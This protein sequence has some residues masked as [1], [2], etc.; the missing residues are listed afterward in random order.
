MNFE[1]MS[2]QRK[3]VLI[4]AAIGIISM[5]LPWVSFFGRNINGMRGWGIVVFFCFVV[6]A[7]MCLM[8]DQ[9]KNLSRT[10]WMV[11]MI[12]GSIAVLILGI[13]F[14]RSFNALNLV[15]FGFYGAWAAAVGVTSWAYN[16]R[17][18]TDSLQGGFDS[19]KENINTKMKAT[20]TNSDNT[21]SGNRP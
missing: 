21:A 13:S 8:G 5:F 14:I 4:A 6:A 3:W 1:T 18:A 2:K 17:S 10:N 20:N 16:Y 7:A 11:T 15:S 19:L 12:A 9:T